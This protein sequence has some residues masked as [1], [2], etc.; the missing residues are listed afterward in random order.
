MNNTRFVIFFF[1]SILYYSTYSQNHRIDSLLKRLEN[2]PSSEKIVVLNHLTQYFQDENISKA[3]S[4]SNDAVRLA[5]SLNDSAGLA[6]AL[7][8]LGYIQLQIGEN[9]SAF[10]TITRC[11]NLYNLTENKIGI[12]RTLDN[13]GSLL[14]LSGSFEK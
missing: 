11:Y 5:E 7:Y 14:R 1:F 13:L 6:E 8:N 4:Y 9:N 3:K 10:K 12:A 2:S